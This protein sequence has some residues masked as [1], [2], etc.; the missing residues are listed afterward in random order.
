VG[1]TKMFMSRTK[2]CVTTAVALTALVAGS[3]F[4]AKWHPRK[5]VIRTVRT[6]TGV[7]THTISNASPTFARPTNDLAVG[8]GEGQLVT[9]SQPISDFFFSQPGIA[10][11]RMKSL[12]QFYIYGEGQGITSFYATNKAGQMVYSANVQVGQNIDSVDRMLQ[13]AMPEA[14]LHVTRLPGM[15]LLTGTVLNP[16]DA[17]QANDLV[18]SYL[19][20]GVKILNHIKTATP[21]QVMLQVR[22]SEVS[23]SVAKNIGVNLKNIQTDPF[24]AGKPIVEGSVGR[25]AGT[26]V[27]NK[28]TGITT[29]TA[30]APIP[31]TTNISMYGALF[32][33][34]ILSS[35]DL[36]ESNGDAV[37][38]AQPN[39]TAISG[40]SAS[41]LAGGEIPI[42]VSTTSGAGISISTEF[43][44]Y[45][46]KLSFTPNVLADGRIS[47]HVS[48]EVSSLDYSN[49]ATIGGFSIPG[50][51]TR[52]A[53]TTV[54]LGSGQ[55]MVISGLMS[56]SSDNTYSRTPGAGDVPV[57]GALFRSNAYKR[58]ETELMIV[59]T[60]Y[61]VKP[62][63]ANE[64]VLPTDGY[65]APTDLQRVFLGKGRGGGAGGPKVKP[66]MAPPATKVTPELGA[67][68]PLPQPA[69]AAQAPAPAP[70]APQ[71]V[72]DAATVAQPAPTKKGHKA[73]QTVSGDAAPG[74]GS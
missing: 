44:T 68:D 43:R 49:A 27:L 26:A 47:L 64:I 67:L 56:N 14:Q 29:F 50:M 71:Q 37:T 18:K 6:S 40:E 72:G 25:D 63:N 34:N 28:T 60:P 55:S 3:A 23:H 22:I 45:G 2:L 20:D 52:R 59:V 35:L 11:V 19:G 38:L 30:S 36:A 1:K 53:D 65:K 62:V 31:N 21:Q 13:V 66:Q 33:T 42:P 17:A 8:K 61:L 7:V 69:V 54:E 70:A 74:F 5:H 16:E 41:F 32:G 58:G 12:T 4:A 39:L 46:I 10:N 51:K 24:S 48:P 9:V 57:L 73:K 15:A